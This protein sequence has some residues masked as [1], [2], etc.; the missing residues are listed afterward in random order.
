M[1]TNTHVLHYC[2]RV[3]V[4]DTRGVATDIT[5]YLPDEIGKWAKEQ[6]LGLSRMLR[7][8]VEG[9]KRHSDARA[10]ATEEGFER[11]EVYDSKRER[12]VAFQGCRIGRSFERE[13]LEAWLTPKDAIAVYDADAQELYVYDDY[14]EFATPDWPS[15][16]VAEVAGALGEKYVE[17][18]D[19]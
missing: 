1:L 14:G 18:L 9:V 10:K 15:N 8:A 11:V 17:E 13:Q 19:I 16:L 5:I 4:L 12:D 2:A 3:K 6:D 7:D